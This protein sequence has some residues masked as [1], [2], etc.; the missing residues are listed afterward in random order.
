ADAVL[1][2]LGLMTG[3][4]RVSLGL[5]LH[6]GLQVVAT[7]TGADLG[8]RQNFT[9]LLAAA[10]QEALD[11][12]ASVVYPLPVGS[13]PVLCF[14]H[15]ELARAN[16]GLSVLT[17]PI[18]GADRVVGALLLERQGGFNE[19]A[20]RLAQDAALFVGPVLELKHRV[21]SPVAGRLI[22]A[23]APRGLRLGEHHASGWR[24]VAGGLILALAV[25]A[26]WPV[27]FRIVAPARVE[28]ID[29]RI[30]AAPVDGFIAS[31]AVRPGEAVRAGQVLGS[32]EDRDLLLQRDKAA[33]E[34]GQYDKQYREALAGDDAGLMVMARAKL[35]QAR[36]QHALAASELERT[37]LRAP[38]DGVLIDGDLSSMIGSPV[39]RGQPL[40]TVSPTRGF[41]VVAEVDDQDVTVLRD[42]Q[43]AQVLFAGLG[44]APAAFTITRIAPV[45]VTLDQRNVFEVEG[46]VDGADAA[47]LRPGLRGV[48]R[49]DVD[50]RL[51]AQVWWLRASHWLRRTLWQLMG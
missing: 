33:A 4:E 10:M 43:Q 21:E 31:V 30:L 45:A 27:T 18:L 17:V 51:Q 6:S 38:F 5:Q 19:R 29:Q 20:L 23:V 35:D 15:G 9:E 47:A 7:S 24:L 36:A 26:L 48:S 2:G 16:G 34:I 42:G 12:R 11:Q 41:K 49:I 25:A 14:A 22:E 3:C 1:G 40:L 39:T 46:R 28:G 32:L 37:R 44:Q 50:Q 13:T 8:Q